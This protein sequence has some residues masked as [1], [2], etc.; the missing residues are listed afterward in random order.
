MKT[1][2]H[3]FISLLRL[4]NVTGKRCRENKKKQILCSVT[5]FFFE[6][7]AVYDIVWKN[8]VQPDRP[9][10]TTWRIR[11]A[12]WITKATGTPTEYVILIPFPLQ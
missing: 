8:V 5:L 9:Q 7:R 10:M 6:N 3:F 4:R 2:I 1:N 11:D 12:C